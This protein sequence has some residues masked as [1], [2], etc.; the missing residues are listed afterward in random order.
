MEILVVTL[1]VSAILVISYI[2]FGREVNKQKEVE[3][4]KNVLLHDFYQQE[5]KNIGKLRLEGTGNDGNSD[6]EFIQ[7]VKKINL[8]DNTRV[9]IYD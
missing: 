6:F 2:I 9:Q 4:R 1:A 8:S 3:D 7:A 5:V